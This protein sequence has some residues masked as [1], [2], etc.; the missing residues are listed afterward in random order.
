MMTKSIP[1]DGRRLRPK[2][3]FLGPPGSGK[4]THARYVA[5]QL[6]VP[7]VSTGELLRREIEAQTSLG[8]GVAEAVRAGELVPDGT[9]AALVDRELRSERASGG[10]ILDGAPRTASQAEMLAPLIEEQEP[11]IV[12]ALEVDDD[13]LRRRLAQRRTEEQRD[14]DAPQVVEDRLSVWARTGPELLGRYAR[15]GL[16]VSVDGTGSISGVSARVWAASVDAIEARPA[17]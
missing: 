14:D 17:M 7:H 16:L 12:V 3:V 15:R 2:L 6:S 1:Q 5:Q 4:G 11:A 10:W 8:N 13:E 9:I